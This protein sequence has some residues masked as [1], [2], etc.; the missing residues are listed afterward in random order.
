M[1]LSALE[2]KDKVPDNEALRSVLGRSVV[3]WHNLKSHLASEYEPVTEH[4][5]MIPQKGFFL[6]D[7]VLGETTVQAAHEVGLPST[8]MEAIEAAP[9]SAEG[10]G[11]RL[12]VGTRTDVES[13]KKLA[14]VK[15]VN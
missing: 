11:F 15:M 12:A 2:N 10:R 1:A 9:K 3:Q 14:A 7:F 5:Y 4:V 6:A 13:I 8:I